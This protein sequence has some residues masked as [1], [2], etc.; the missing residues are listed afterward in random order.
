ML[1]LNLSTPASAIFLSRA[2]SYAD[3]RR[4]TYMEPYLN[5]VDNILE[6]GTLKEK[7]T[8]IPA[9]TISAPHPPA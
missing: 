6:K 4:W 7:R 1:F 5:I 8:A 2:L 9:F 3:G